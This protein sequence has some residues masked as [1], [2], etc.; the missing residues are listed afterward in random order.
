MLLDS[1]AEMA[2]IT[3]DIV[4]RVDAQIDKSEK[5]DLSGIATIPIESI[6]I[7]R[8]LPIILTSGCTI[9][10]DF[11]VVKHYK[12]MLIFPNPLLKKYKCTID[13]G[14]DKMEIYYNDKKFIIPVTMHKVK[15]KL[16]V[17]Y[18]TTSQNDKSLVSDQITQEVESDSRE[19]N[20]T[21]N[22]SLLKK[23]TYEL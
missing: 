18:A 11:V 1:G 2:I 22:D 21:A 17:N 3:E 7:V 8:N 20:F 9:Y 13:W 12:S 5:Y 6:G 19:V 10:E 15:N 14:N 4:K 16:E 23:K